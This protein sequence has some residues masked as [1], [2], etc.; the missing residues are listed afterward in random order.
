[1]EICKVCFIMVVIIFFMFLVVVYVDLFFD[2]FK[3]VNVVKFYINYKIFCKEI[4]FGG[5]EKFVCCIKV[6][7]F[8]GFLVCKNM[9]FYGILCL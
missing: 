6:V 5:E 8:I 4:V 1:M 7:L 3:K 9:L 2:V